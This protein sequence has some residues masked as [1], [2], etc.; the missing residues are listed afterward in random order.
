MAVY[1]KTYRG[2]AGPLAPAWSRFFVITRYAFQDMRRK[3]FLSTFFLLSF[4]FPLLAAL[5]I[6][7]RHNAEVLEFLGPKAF[8]NFAIDSQYFLSFLG[9][10]SML[11]FFLAA[12]AGPGQISPDLAN[13][14]LPLYL[15]RPFSRAEYVLGKST[16][17][18]ILLS[19]MTWVPGLLLFG[20]QSYLEGWTWFTDN[21]RIAGGLFFG[22]WIW[23]LVVSFLALA[24]SAW[25]KWK[26]VAGAL[27][28]GIV[29]V[30]GGFSGMVNSLLD[31]RWGYLLNIRHVVGH[32]W[33]SLFEAPIKRGS[34]AAF[35]GVGRAEENLPIEWCWVALIAFCLLSL[36]LLA[37][38]IRGVEVVK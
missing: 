18:F 6:Y 34:G 22:A 23:I 36:Y 27:L 26:P 7:L 15:S 37:R 3:R 14:A 35:F 16:V 24:L 1:K 13:N 25:V 4:I 21:L 33:V 32:I 31:T 11:A 2:Y 5:A 20:L 17:L 28:F 8:K 10:Q 19:V 38:K 29:F 9:F 30:A 12:F